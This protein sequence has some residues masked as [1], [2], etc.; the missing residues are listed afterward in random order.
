[1]EAVFQQYVDAEEESDQEVEMDEP[2]RQKSPRGLYDQ[3]LAVNTS[4]L[5]GAQSYK[6]VRRVTELL[7]YYDAIIEDFNEAK[8]GDILYGDPLT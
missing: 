5:T 6:K 2:P 3:I 4:L 7:K 1:M 8:E